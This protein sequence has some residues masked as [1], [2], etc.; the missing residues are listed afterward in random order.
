MPY[1]KLTGDSSGL[2]PESPLTYFRRKI[3]MCEIPLTL[4]QKLFAA[5]NHDLVYKFLQERHLSISDYYDIVIFGYL[6]AVRRYL[7]EGKLHHYRFATIAWNC[8]KVDLINHSKSQNRQKHNTETVSLQN[9]FIEEDFSLEKVIAT[10]ND[11]MSQ[12]ETELIL[13]DLA[14]R[15]SQQQMDIVRM[16]SSGYNLQDIANHHNTSIKRIRRLLEEVRSVLM[17]ICYE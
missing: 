16:R 7:D 6:R 2:L 9:E 10:S 3:Y 12:L 11:L 8:M 14:R 17:E 5:Q 1:T 13:H 15:V 4:E